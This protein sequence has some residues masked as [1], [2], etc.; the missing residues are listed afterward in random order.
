METIF[1]GILQGVLEWLPI[2]SRGNL[3]LA[4]VGIFGYSAKKALELSVFLHWGTLLAA[5]IYFRKDIKEI[6]AGLK[7]YKLAFKF[8][9]TQENKL[10]SFLLVSTLLTGFI[11]YPLFK[12]LLITSSFPGEILIGLVGVSLILSG[13]L[14]KIAAERNQ[15]LKTKENLCLKDSILLGI[16]Q[17]FSI[18]PGIS[19]S[20]ITSSAFLFL[21]YKPE[22]AL[23][24]SFLMS[25]PAVLAAEVGLKLIEGLTTINLIDALVGI[26]F[27]FLFGI[28]TIHLFLKIAKKINFWLFCIV[29]GIISLIP[30]VFYFF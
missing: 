12:L 6:F 22:T 8:G 18:I 2:S 3:V 24:L 23:N 16:A 1:F 28:L 7:S 15:S 10:I 27:S 26:F 20:G 21:G 29:L 9:E 4:M 30:L 17:G 11:G 14:Q 13:I 25:I 19:R 5:M